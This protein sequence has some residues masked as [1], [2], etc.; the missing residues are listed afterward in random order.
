MKF[1]YPSF[2]VFQFQKTTKKNRTSSD[3]VWRQFFARLAQKRKLSFS[4]FWLHCDRE[5]MSPKV[6]GTGKTSSADQH[7]RF[8]RPCKSRFSLELIFLLYNVWVRATSHFPLQPW[9]HFWQPPACTEGT[10]EQTLPTC[11]PGDQVDRFNPTASFFWSHQ[12][13]R[14]F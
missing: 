12:N 10:G 14:F 9:F 5:I 8:G 11:L 6:V 13:S 2:T 7:A 4:I 3:G 1:L